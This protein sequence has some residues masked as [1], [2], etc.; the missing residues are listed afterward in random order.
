MIVKCLRCKKEFKTVPAKIKD[1]KGKYC[2][3]KCYF[4][5]FARKC[6]VCKEEFRT[7]P[8]RI[9]IGKGKFCSKQ[10]HN[11]FMTGKT[12]VSS[13]KFIKGI[14]P[15]NKNSISLTCTSCGKKFECP[16]SQKWRLTCSEDCR[17]TKRV[18]KS[19]AYIIFNNS[20][21]K[22]RTSSAYRYWRRKILDRDK[23]TCTLCGYK[24]MGMFNGK[25][26]LVADHIKPFSIYPDLRFDVNN[27]R[28]LCV[29]CHQKQPTTGRSKEKLNLL[30]NSSGTIIQV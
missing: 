3:K 22:L 15:W 23:N 24:G 1:G 17:V 4:P 12:N 26:D 16:P 5:V 10:C 7:S 14:I 8:S 20:M 11:R 18:A 9:G 13:S 25:S 29:W 2:S 28:T 6:K 27:G 19:A 21:I 30:F